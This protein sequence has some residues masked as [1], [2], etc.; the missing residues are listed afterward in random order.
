[1]RRVRNKQIAIRL[2]ECERSA[3]SA[4]AVERDMPVSMVV[5]MAIKR[6]LAGRERTAHQ[7]PVREEAL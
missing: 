5:R 3:L 6:M 1:M 7:A 2:Q 4:L